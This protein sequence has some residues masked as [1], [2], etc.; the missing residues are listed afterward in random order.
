MAHT[1]TPDEGG[2]P[3]PRRKFSRVIDAVLFVAII[4]VLVL[5]LFP[6]KS[7]PSV[8]EPAAVLTLNTVGDAQKSSRTLPGHLERPL[9]IEAF[10]S[11]CGACKRNAGLLGDLDDA[12]KEGQLDVVA[13]SVD[14][15]PE[16]ALSAKL[17]WPIPVDVLHD[18]SGKFSRAYQVDVLPTYILIGKNGRVKRVNS[19]NPG[20]SDIRAWL[21][22]H[23]AE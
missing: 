11:W 8:G 4:G 14:E 12:Q 9:L 1:S 7:G 16:Q 18:A 17:S 6:R 15:T 22:E 20:A 3:A 23:K 13:V 2:F 19:G 5:A 21:H 10:A